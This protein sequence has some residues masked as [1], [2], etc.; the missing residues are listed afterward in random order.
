M[1]WSFDPILF[2]TAV[3]ALLFAY[4]EYSR[5]TRVR[6]KIVNFT[7]SERASRGP[8]EMRVV[9]LL[10]A[11]VRN[12]GIPLHDPL[13]VLGFRG[14]DGPGWFSCPFEG[15]KEHGWQQ[16]E[17]ARG[18]MGEFV[19]TEDQFDLRGVQMSSLLV[20]P[21][22]QKA[23]LSLYSQGFLVCSRRIGGYRDK[24]GRLM[25]RVIFPFN[26]MFTVNV[27]IPGSQET[28]LKTREIIHPF[29]VVEDHLRLF[30]QE[31]KRHSA[32]NASSP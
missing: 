21:A 5:N 11:H 7:Y 24:L 18:M 30:I 29:I 19:L 28:L 17:F 16:G 27:P 22:A 9:R 14:S 26:S 31:V 12:H 23:K 6:L 4:H 32:P 25:N 20:D 2:V 15:S 1:Q 3:L 8:G 10:A 13:L